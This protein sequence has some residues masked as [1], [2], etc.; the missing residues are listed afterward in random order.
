MHPTMTTAPT[1]QDIAQLYQAR[2]LSDA[3]A[4]CQRLLAVEPDNARA[5]LLGGDIALAM[6]DKATARARLQRI[7][8]R[9]DASPEWRYN[10]AVLIARSGDLSGAAAILREMA[11]Q[12]PDV[13]PVLFD[14]AQMEEALG[15]PDMALQAYDGAIA[16]NPGHAGPF[17]RRAVL[18]LRKA[19]G[20]ALPTPP[21]KSQSPGQHG[22]IAMSSLGWNGRFGNQLLQYACLR[23][24][25]AVHGLS[26]ETPGW[27]GRWLFD[28]NDPAP[29]APLPELREDGENLAQLML[30]GSTATSMAN[31]D[32][33][34]YACYNTRF[35]QP[36]RDLMRRL[37]TPG[38]HVQPFT[39]AINAKIAARGKTL[40]AIHL[41][42]GDFGYD[43]FWIAPETWYLDWLSELWPRL[44][45]PV[46]YIA[47]DDDQIFR[48]FAAYAP[49][50]AADFETPLAGA[51]F[52]GDFHV[53]TQADHLAI[54]NSSFSFVAGLLNAHAQSFLR[55]DLANKRLVAYDPW[56]SDVLLPNLESTNMER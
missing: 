45:R 50:T 36:H 46:L 13:F 52:Y 18:L 9:G 16:A 55:P 25:G 19:F 1:L 4:A 5:L 26:I 10:A 42:R 21:E 47:S 20:E 38:A 56:A 31:R 32:L 34:G 51:E 44:D 40:V 7:A 54:S 8:A 33:W 49:V 37:F 15:R 14:L 2:R 43:R 53:L 28:L 27:I 24:I 3:E 29:R 6:G 23:A 48:K 30:P 41:R 11:A 17:T 35:Y 22:R 39:N 12:H